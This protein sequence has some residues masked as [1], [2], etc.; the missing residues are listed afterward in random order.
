MAAISATAIVS[1]SAAA[2]A[3]GVLSSGNSRCARAAAA[4]RARETPKARSG[5]RSSA[6][7]ANAAT[8]GAA[9]SP[10]TPACATPA[11]ACSSAPP[12]CCT[13]RL[14]ASEPESPRPRGRERGERR[15]P[16]R[17]HRRAEPKR[18][19]RAD[20]HRPRR[21]SQRGQHRRRGQQPQAHGR[22]CARLVVA[23]GQRQ[24]EFV[25]RAGHH[26]DVGGH[27]REQVIGAELRRRVQA[28]EQRPEQQRQPLRQRAA[29]EQGERGAQQRHGRPNARTTRSWSASDRSALMG[30]LSTR[31][32]T[33]SLTGH[34]RGGAYAAYAG[35]WC[36]GRG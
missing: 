21:R 7:A 24:R 12:P 26:G 34:G 6:A 28:R 27:R 5:T 11:P 35:W 31:C 30:R 33:A 15:E 23:A 20:G 1:C 16:E 25:A 17:R 13:T 9:T 32:A 36:S 2:N 14:A 10:A 8:T 18:P 19:A 29:G 4:H 22:Q 3:C